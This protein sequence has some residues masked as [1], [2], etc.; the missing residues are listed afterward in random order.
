M[1]ASHLVEHPCR[2]NQY[3]IVSE[4]LQTLSG[5]CEDNSVKVDVMVHGRSRLT[6]EGM[7]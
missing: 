2:C 4:G 7:Q 6:S 1:E 3:E 5:V